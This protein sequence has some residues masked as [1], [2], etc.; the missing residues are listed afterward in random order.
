MS[1]IREL[2]GYMSTGTPH[3][4]MLSAPNPL[5]STTPVGKQLRVC[6]AGTGSAY[7]TYD[8]PGWDLIRSDDDKYYIATDGENDYVVR[9]ASIHERFFLFSESRLLELADEFA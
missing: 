9:Q 6:G 2:L 3:C 8:L 4:I 5:D 7:I 1:E